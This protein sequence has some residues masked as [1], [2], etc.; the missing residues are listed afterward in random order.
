MLTILKT[1]PPNSPLSDR[2]YRPS[3]Q[4]QLTR[5]N[6]GYNYIL[7]AA[8]RAPDGEIAVNEP[9][10]SFLI[11]RQYPLCYINPH[12]LHFRTKHAA[13]F[14][15]IY[16]LNCKHN[17]TSRV[18]PKAISPCG[19]CVPAILQFHQALHAI[20]NDTQKSN[21]GIAARYNGAKETE[22]G[23]SSSGC[24]QRYSVLQG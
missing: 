9:L 19:S 1:A 5:C 2:W 17:Y 7:S 3:L 21:A 8:A 20:V 22:A 16:F 18:V 14:R 11:T 12:D 4:R 15:N 6:A 24:G 10:Y 23:P 13:P